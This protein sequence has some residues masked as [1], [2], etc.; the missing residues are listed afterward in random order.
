MTMLSAGI[1]NELG[2]GGTV[3]EDWEGSSPL[4][5]WSGDTGDAT[6][7]DSN[8]YEGSHSV[9]ATSSNYS[10]IITKDGTDYGPADTPFSVYIH[11]QDNPRHGGIAFGGQNSNGYSGFS[12]YV[13]THSPDYL[14]LYRYDSGSRT[15]L[16][17]TYF[18]ALTEFRIVLSEWKSDGS[19]TAELRDL[20][21]NVKETL[22]TTDGTHGSGRV[23][24]RFGDPFTSDYLTVDGV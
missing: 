22:S 19:M 20:N 18:G 5:D 14:Y 11:N 9:Q 2:G 13:A 15:E 7:A 24:V 8:Y 21:G 23:G 10:V 4:S 1:I 3:V 12:G 16:G 17:G 6:V